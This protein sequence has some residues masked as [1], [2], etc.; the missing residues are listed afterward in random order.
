[1]PVRYLKADQMAAMINAAVPEATVQPGPQENSLVVTADAIQWE[2]IRSL[3]AA[4]DV[5]PPPAQATRAVYYVKYLSASELMDSLVAL[6]PD[7]R[8]T[9]A[10]R[11]FTPSVT[12]PTGGAGGTAQMLSAPQF[13]AS[14]AGGGAVTGDQIAPVNALVLSGAPYT[15]EQGMALAAQLDTAPP[16]VHI[17]AMV[18][19]VRREDITRLGIDW[20]P[21]IEAGLGGTGVPFVIGEAIPAGAPVGGIPARGLELGKI[22]RSFLQWSASIRALEEQGRARVLSNPSVTVLDGR[23]TSLHTGETYYYEVAVAAATTGIV[24]DIRTFDVGIT[25]NVT[26]RVNNDETVTLTISPGVAALQ[27]T[28]EFDLPVV[29]ERTVM[30]TV[31]VGTGETAVIAGL[32]T[33]EEQIT[34]KKVPLLGDIPLLGELFKHRERRPAH[35]EILVFVTPTIVEA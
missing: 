3:I 21:T 31:R 12:K 23:Q 33:D 35:R 32:I 20:G 19:E 8:V 34:V 4:S 6:V 17:Q 27:G 2:A 13:A 16:Q 22:E 11:S 15:V 10:P 30:T 18:T 1:M 29:T 7:L 25:L 14:A 28:S 9:L 5:A 26:P 24:N